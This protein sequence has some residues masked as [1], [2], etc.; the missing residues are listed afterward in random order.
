MTDEIFIPAVYLRENC[1]FC[2]KVRLFLLEADLLGETEIRELA[3]GSMEEAEIRAELK[4]GLG[5][6]SFPAAKIGPKSYMTESDDII[7]FFAARSGREPKKMPVLKNYIEGVLKP[8]LRLSQ[9]IFE[10]ETQAL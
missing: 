8:M 4:A 5:R 7:A 3:P 9:Q 10:L 1:P 2:L 6:A